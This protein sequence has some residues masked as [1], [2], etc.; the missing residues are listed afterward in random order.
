MPEIRQDPISG[1]WAIIAP[2][3]GRRPTDF[4]LPEE[5][6]EK[7]RCPLCP[8]NEEL[9]PPELYRYPASGPWK[10][11]VVPNKYPAL[12]PEIPFEERREFFTSISGFGGHE[13]IIENPE[14][15]RTFTTFSLEEIVWIWQAY[16]ARFSAWEKRL[17]AGYILVFKNHGSAAGASLS[18]E[19]SQLVALPF[20]PPLVAAEIERSRRFWEAS[21]ECLFCELLRQEESGPRL[22]W[23]SKDY[24]AFCA[25]A[26]RQPLEVWLFPRK[27]QSDFR[28][29][30]AQDP[31]ALAEALR[32]VLRK[33]DRALPG[34]P[35]NWVL[36]TAPPQEP[37]RPYFHWHLELIPVLTKVAGFEWGSGIHIIPVSP[38][39][40]AAA[41]RAL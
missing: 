18:H 32:E 25:Y 4:V 39:E 3:R 38:E 28:K 2:E 1:R 14:H 6:I 29:S 22:V 19:H 40:G 17:K 23:K 37:E 7:G 15:Q 35:Y 36:H 26:P 13:V 8:G 24:L 12:R 27:H 20:I 21:G 10:V 34:L 33:L 9:T 5:E 41:I 30:L 16:K 11:R 31:Q